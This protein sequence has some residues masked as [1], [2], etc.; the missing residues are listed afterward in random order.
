MAP[1]MI[2]STMLNNYPRWWSPHWDA[3]GHGEG[4]LNGSQNATAEGND[5]AHLTLPYLRRRATRR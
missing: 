3:F 1:K 4:G 5:R 2:A